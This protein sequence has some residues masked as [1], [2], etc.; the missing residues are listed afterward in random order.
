[1]K[2]CM[3]FPAAVALA[4]LAACSKT[5]RVDPLSGGN[6][7]AGK[8]LIERYGCAACHEIKG[9]AHAR[10]QVGPSLKTIR[11]ASYVAGVLPSSAANLETWIMRP[12]EVDPKTAMPDLGV[13]QAEARDIAA[14]LYSQ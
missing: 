6:P 14:Y 10:S 8:A 3:W 12:R 4:A 13:T 7:R 2:R 1:M 9:V 11:D 5:P